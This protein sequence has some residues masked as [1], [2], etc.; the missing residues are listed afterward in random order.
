MERVRSVAAAPGPQAR[1]PGQTAAAAAPDDAEFPAR[2]RRLCQQLALA[3][4]RQYSADL[5][6]RLNRLALRGHALLYGARDDRKNLALTFIAGGFSRLVRAEWR[7]V[8]VAGALFFGPLLALIVVLQFYPD[9]VYY[10]MN[11]RQ[12][13]NFEEMYNPTAERL[14]RTREADSSF[15]MLGVYIWNNIKI[16]F[17]TFAGGLLFGLGTIFFL[18]FNGMLIGAVAGHLIQIG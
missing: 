9:F 2:Y 1:G 12:I 6:D 15:L 13:A 5:V 14:G 16:G 11:P 8:A 7:V 3:R 18:L 17:Q 4:D 10:V